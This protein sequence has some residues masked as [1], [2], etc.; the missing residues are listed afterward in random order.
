MLLQSWPPDC[1]EGI[2]PFHLKGETWRKL[3]SSPRSQCR[4]VFK[5]NERFWRCR[6]ELHLPQLSGSFEGIPAEAQECL[7]N[8]WFSSEAVKVSMFFFVCVLI[9]IGQQGFTAALN[10]FH[11]CQNALAEMAVLY[12]WHL[13][14]FWHRPRQAEQNAAWRVLEKL[15]LVK[16]VAWCWKWEG[17]DNQEAFSWKSCFWYTRLRV[18][19][20]AN[21]RLVL[22]FKD[23]NVLVA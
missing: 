13:A 18:M 19:I 20:W 6:V 17:L 10:G 16:V 9:F 15:K 4:F 12:Q 5:G 7:D 2:I 1:L 14:F 11:S 3:S 22:S 23:K 21:E 8:L